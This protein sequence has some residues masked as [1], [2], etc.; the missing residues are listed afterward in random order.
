MQ[1]F[2]DMFARE[3]SNPIGAWELNEDTG[4]IAYDSSG[5]GNNALLNAN[6]TWRNDSTISSVIS[7]AISSPGS[8]QKPKKSQQEPPL[9][10]SETLS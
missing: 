6:A 10:P 8:T 4:G 9:P 5:N 1:T 3:I 2:K 7:P